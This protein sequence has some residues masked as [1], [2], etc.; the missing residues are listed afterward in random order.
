MKKVV[1]FLM[2]VAALSLVFIGCPS[3]P[4]PKE[5]PVATPK[6]EVKP[7]A[8]K[9]DIIDHKDYK[10]GKDVP[11]WVTMDVTEL[12][13][14]PEYEGMYLFKFESPRAQ[15]LEG[16]R[17]YVENM[18]AA[19][20]IARIVSTRVQQKFAGAAAG[21]LDK[22]E[23]YMEAVTKVLAE[24]TVTGYRKLADYWVQMRYYREDGSVDEDA[25]TFLA[26]YGV[27]KTTLDD[28]VRKALED[29]DNQNKPKSE[30]EKTARDRVKEAFAEGF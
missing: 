18:Q 13:K 23:V 29:A 5:E 6:P 14:L 22:L 25:Y 20:E 28:M 12:E 27:D 7:V 10:W 24:A 16:A 26:L 4:K 11:D 9:P 19:T 21:D 3:A 15:D 17:L 30:E 1:L 2:A 8:K